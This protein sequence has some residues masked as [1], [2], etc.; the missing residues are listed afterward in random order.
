[1]CNNQQLLI[2]NWKIPF[3]GKKLEKKFEANY[4]E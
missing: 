3:E 2:L 1:M 4:L